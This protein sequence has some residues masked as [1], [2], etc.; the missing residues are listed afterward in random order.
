MS[1]VVCRSLRR[2]PGAVV[3]RSYRFE[4]ALT[5]QDGKA[6]GRPVG[7]RSRRL[8]S[9]LP[10][11][12]EEEAA[13]FGLLRRSDDDRQAM[14]DE[15]PLQGKPR[16]GRRVE[17]LVPV[18]EPAQRLALIPVAMGTLKRDER[19]APLDHR[20]S[21]D[22]EVGPCCASQISESRL[23]DLDALQRPA[24]ENEIV[25]FAGKRLARVD[26]A[27]IRQEHPSGGAEVRE[28]DAGIANGYAGE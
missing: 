14:E 19:R 15:L 13:N 11:M 23:P 12:A 8:R 18:E 21:R 10:G 9:R 28:V 27:R 7:E 6:A 3:R 20:K 2:P 24:G 25:S 5:L 17:Q 16:R 1:S 4:V 22:I 26:E